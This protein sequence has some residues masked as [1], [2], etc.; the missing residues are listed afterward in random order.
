MLH[1]GTTEMFWECLTCSAREGSTIE[2]REQEGIRDLV[3]AEGED[4]KRIAFSADIDL[5]DPD[6]GAFAVWYRLIRQFSLR[7]LTF[8][9]DRLPAVAGLAATMA[10]N[11]GCHY[12]AGVWRE[13]LEGLL[14]HV[15]PAE[16]TTRSMTYPDLLAVDHGPRVA[17]VPTWSWASVAGP[18]TYVPARE[19]RCHNELA[20]SVVKIDLK[21]DADSPYAKIEG[22]SITLLAV[23]R[24]V[25]CFTHLAAGIR[26]FRPSDIALH[27]LDAGN[28]SGLS[29]RGFPTAAGFDEYSMYEQTTHEP[30]HVLDPHQFKADASMLPES[31]KSFMAVMVAERYSE[32]RGGRKTYFLIVKEDE[33]RHGH[34]NRIGMGWSYG[35]D[36][37]DCE[38][39]E[40]TLL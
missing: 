18:I 31:L 28:D 17:L 13:D 34:W 14:W 6:F 8:A 9:D 23:C 26:S 3:T 33:I 35:W 19:E 15:E 7:N 5:L 11:T 1:F 39:Q 25:A 36:L 16:D 4:F 20:A 27:W 12:L 32:A 29:H 40:V 2:H 37:D 10:K 30:T 38:R 24:K 21:V 22:G